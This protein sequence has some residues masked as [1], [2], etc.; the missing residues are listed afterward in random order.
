MG[1]KEPNILVALANIPV[2][3]R[4]ERDAAALRIS[5]DLLSR[6]LE[7]GETQIVKPSNAANTLAGEI[8]DV[9]SDA[10]AVVLH[11][12]LDDFLRSIAARGLHGRLFA[13]SLFLHFAR[14]IPLSAGYTAND[15]LQQSDLQ[16]AAQAWLMQ[17]RYLAS[18]AQHFGPARVRFLSSKA[19]LADTPGVL[20]ALADFFNVDGSA[21]YWRE[22]AT[23]PVFT[24]H[25]KSP[26]RAFDAD[27]RAA[28]QTAVRAA[29]G[30]EVDAVLQWSAALAR[31][32]AA[33]LHLGDTLVETTP[34][35]RLRLPK[36]WL[37]DEIHFG[38]SA[39]LALAFG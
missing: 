15:L 31:H 4:R 16:I 21:D 33:P 39:Q 22:V 6:P 1:L 24:R 3:A 18:V 35:P 27:A 20:S 11:S 23:G 14:E 10:K 37:P 9:R 26:D 28:A 19:L 25:S 30:D 8:L 36:R 5:L 34:Q 12:S 2:S 32:C 7:L 29:H 13:R 17:A 38:T